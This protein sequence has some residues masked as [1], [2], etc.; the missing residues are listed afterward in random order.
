MF[1]TGKNNI[2]LKL[3]I[4]FM[5][6]ISTVYC[7]PSTSLDNEQTLDGAK[8]IESQKMKPEN[9]VNEISDTSKFAPSPMPS[10]YELA[11]VTTN[12]NIELMMGNQPDQLHSTK[13]ITSSDETEHTWPTW[14]LDGKKIAYSTIATASDSGLQMSLH[15]ADLDNTFNQEVYKSESTRK[16]PYLAPRT[17]HYVSWSPRGDQLAFLTAGDKNGLLSLLLADDDD[18]SKVEKITQAANLYFRWDHRGQ[19]ILLHQDGSLRI[20]DTN[21]DL[22]PVQIGPTS[23]KYRVPDWAPQS[24]Q[25]AY[26]ETSQSGSRLFVNDVGAIENEPVMNINDSAAFSWSPAND[27][28]AIANLH[29]SESTY[30]D[31]HLFDPLD[32]SLDELIN[33]PFVAFY[34]NPSGEQIVYFIQTGSENEVAVKVADLANKQKRN[35]YAF[36]PTQELAVHFAYFDQFSPSHSLFSADGKYLV[37]AGY[38]NNRQTN[39]DPE[40][41][42][43]DILGSE[44]PTVITNG[45]IAFFAPTK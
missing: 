23:Q 24:H 45:R 31:L 38:P 3:I 10:T 32:G 15:L 26:I 18:P 28:L 4:A 13:L 16:F 41:I 33:E 8:P 40:I 44:E 36:V 14:S 35:I 17:P 11:L 9:S 22:Y 7:V 34:W 5:I 2:S 12:G 30:S 6:L 29:S 1:S 25:I 43:I 20:V 27:L 39:Q 37:I 42:M 19:T 21:L